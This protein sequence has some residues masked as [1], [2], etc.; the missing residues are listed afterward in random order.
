MA[1][2]FEEDQDIRYEKRTKKLK[3]LTGFLVKK[4]WFKSKG[5]VDAIFI[6]IILISIIVS[7]VIRENRIRSEDQID[8][9]RIPTS[10]EIR[11]QLKLK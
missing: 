9:I 5:E 1:I 8:N 6:I 2:E 11:V 10:Q 4:G 7:F 3:G